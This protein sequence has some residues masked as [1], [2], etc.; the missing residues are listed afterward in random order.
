MYKKLKYMSDQHEFL[1]DKIDQ[2]ASHFQ[3]STSTTSKNEHTKPI[4]YNSA[5]TLA[6]MSLSEL[7]DYLQKSTKD[8]L[9]QRKIIFRSCNDRQRCS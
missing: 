6:D 8:A 2:S 1:K 4:L 5:E 3:I 9:L 7:N